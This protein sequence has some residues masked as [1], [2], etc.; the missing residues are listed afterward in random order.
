MKINTYIFEFLPILLLTF[1]FLYT[2]Q[3][4]QIAKT[5]LGRFIAVLIIMYYT[6]IDPVYGLFSVVIIILL[7]QLEINNLLQDGFENYNSYDN[8]NK[9]G[10]HSTPYTNIETL[11]PN[12]FTDVNVAYPTK[13]MDND[14]KYEKIK[15]RFRKE[16]CDAGYLK[17]KQHVVKPDMAEIIF[18]DIKFSNPDQ[19]CNPCDPACGYTVSH[20]NS[21]F[22]IIEPKKSN[23]WVNQNA[24]FMK[25]IFGA[26]TMVSPAEPNKQPIIP[27]LFVN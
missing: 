9:I 5:V 8:D 15:E 26:E 2:K 24:L 17:Y 7:Y 23:D 27:A 13:Q 25:E 12:E 22:D 14:D 3:F 6:L 21:E 18:P 10:I 19:K 1:Y 11:L 20:L 4:V 16:Y